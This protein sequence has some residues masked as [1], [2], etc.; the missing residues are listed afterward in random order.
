MDFGP[1]HIGKWL[2]A[3]GVFLVLAGL[4]FLGLGKLGLFR[5]PGDLAFG[6]KNW[7]VYIPLGT[8]VVLSLL[9]T[10]ISWLIQYFRR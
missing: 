4:L 10:L 6:G 7:K 5:L 3:M 1:Q 8:C 9:L 2:I